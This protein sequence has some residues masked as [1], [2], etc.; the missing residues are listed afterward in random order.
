MK[1]KESGLLILVAAIAL[2]GLFAAAPAHAGLGDKLKNKL[3]AKVQQKTD[4]KVDAAV[5]QDADAAEE[6]G[7][8]GNESS[9]GAASSVAE[10][11]TKFDFVPG[12]KVLFYDDF[13]EDELGEFPHQWTLKLGTVEVAEWKGERWLRSTSSEG[14][15]RMKLP[16]KLPEKWTLEFD[17]YIS[18]PSTC[19]FNIHGMHD[20]YSAWITSLPQY[21]TTLTFSSGPLNSNTPFDKSF[22]VAGR[23]HVM[24][25]AKGLGL[26]VYVDQQRMVNVPE[27]SLAYGEP[28]DL[29]FRLVKGKEEPMI[30]NVRFAEGG[31]P[32][33]EL[34][35][36]G[37]FVSYGILFDT[38]SDVVKPESAPELR[39]IATYLN[40]HPAAK[41]QVIGHT[42]NAGTPAGNLDLSKRRAASVAKA[43]GELGVAA[44]RLS[45]DGKGDTSP[46]AENKDAKGRSLNRRVEFTKS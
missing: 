26:K 27:I 1:R 15:V 30:T 12:S 21:G 34:L 4:Q 28:I 18:D 46:L 6:A 19:S 42:D 2:T 40:A 24:F 20:N 25:M 45:T 23:H 7:G 31:K 44:D 37:K 11:S 29:E 13:T 5:D 43:L 39:Q 36:S 32:A 9:D 14:R 41:L 16:G 8:D 10:V 3:K 22:A 35:D 33:A 38:G 17:I